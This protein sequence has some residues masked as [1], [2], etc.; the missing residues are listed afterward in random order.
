MSSEKIIVFIKIVENSAS[1]QSPILRKLNQNDRLSKIR[2]ELENSVIDDMLLFSKK[3]NDEFGVL[4]YEEEENF[5]LKDVIDDQNILYLKRV[6]W[7][8]LSNQHKLDYGRIMS[9]DGIKI[10][11][12]QAYLIN[13]CELDE[14]ESYKKGQLEF[15]SKEDWIKKT[16]LFVDVD[17]INIT[18]FA[19]L[20]LSVR[21][22]RDKSFNNEVMSA[23][24]YIEIGKVSL[25]FNKEDLKLTEEFKNDVVNAIKSKNSE[26]GFEKIT[27]DYGQFIPTEV[28][29]GGRIYF[30][31]IKK[32]LANS[33]DTSN[34]ASVNIGIGSSNAN[35]GFN[36]NNSETT[37]KFYNFN[38]IGLLGGK[39]PDDENFDE[40]AWIDSLKD[41]QN[42]DCIE[43]KNPISIFQLLSFDDL[44][45]DLPDNLPND[46]QDSRKKIYKSLGNKI[47]YT[48][49]E[50][51]EYF[52]NKPGRFRTFEL[53]NIP[54][55]ILQIVYDK[56]ADIYATIYDANENS[57]NV[58]FNCKILR[59]PGA[60]PSIIIH[61][62]QKEF[63]QCRYKLKIKI[64]IIGYDTD[65][66]PILSDT[67]VELIKNVYD[68]QNSCEFYS[69]PLKQKLDSMLERNIPFFGIPILENFDLSKSLI[70]GHNFRIVDGEYKIDIFSYCLEKKRYVNLPKVTFCTFIISNYPT[71]DSYES[72]PFNFK[73]LKTPFVDLNTSSINP[74]CVSLYFSKNN[75]YKPIFLN[76]KINQIK[77]Y[78][79]QQ[80]LEGH[81]V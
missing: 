25:K 41:Y 39:H 23:Y 72:F 67:S 6:Y 62:I 38:H 53:K 70:I 4:K 45:D 16:N 12:K 54:R 58:F 68:P 18:D 74:K 2:K 30:K 56:K 43:F 81:H 80:E 78:A 57:K 75:D 51:C 34:D 71:S 77:Y 52:L 40:K 14:I 7:K 22:L 5:Y 28:I 59:E 24:K 9:F 42:W 47:L 8:F 66:N 46:L 60:K 33:A 11:N 63:K 69:I 27:D 73:L 32:L 49:T 65:F 10:A 50:E 64:M 26:E 37:S 48:N 79:G 1:L 3:V 13:E 31:D 44:P 35:V 20:G 76:Q 55:N 21:S 17:G 15:E 19:K 61:G 29:L 36:F